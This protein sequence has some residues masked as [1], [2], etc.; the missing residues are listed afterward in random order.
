[1]RQHT[2]TH[3]PKRPPRWYVIVEMQLLCAGVVLLIF[4]L[5]HHV[6]PKNSI[7]QGKSTM[8]VPT[9]QA[10]N[11]TPA[12]SDF[13]PSGSGTAEVNPSPTYA[14]GDF[15]AHFPDYDTGTGCAYSYQSDNLRVAITKKYTQ[16]A[17]YYYAD[18]WVRSIDVFR[19]ETANNEFGTGVRD[20]P[21][22]IANEHN[23]VFAVTGDYFGARAEGLVIRNGN[24]YRESITSDVCLLFADGTM[25][26]YKKDS[27]N[28]SEQLP[29]GIWQG[30][31]FGPCLLEN[32][33]AIE[34]FTDPIRVANPRTAM[35]YFEPGHYCFVVVDGRQ[36]T[37]D[38]MTLSELSEVFAQAGCKC[39]Y[40][41]DGGQ[42]SAMIFQGRIINS[43]SDGG[44]RC[45]DII[46]FGGTHE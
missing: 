39:A 9:Q 46:S 31:S 10:G 11:I 34:Y 20:W 17:S 19:T 14:P 15:S 12:P 44:R 22:N 24:M 16:K 27:I 40:N 32:G 6:I 43:P 8:P 28:L 2:E 37:S 45:S 33:Q 25:E 38:G 41:L 35:G 3:T 30:W 42:T 23:A 29:R 1:M 7:G 36:E 21:L 13:Q 5:F 4:A 18:V 26:T